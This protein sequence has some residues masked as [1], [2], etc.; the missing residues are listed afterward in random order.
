MLEKLFFC[1]I[2]DEINLEYL[3]VCG[4]NF[5]EMSENLIMF[6]NFKIFFKDEVFFFI[7]LEI[8]GFCFLK[9]EILEIGVV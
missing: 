2:Y 8:I 7:D 9:Y 1:F 3:K 4:F 6:K 5:I